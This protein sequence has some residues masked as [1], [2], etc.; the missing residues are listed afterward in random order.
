MKTIQ[1]IDEME[2]K[3]G[4]L[5]NDRCDRKKAEGSHPEIKSRE[6]KDPWIHKE[7]VLFLR[8]W[9]T[10]ITLVREG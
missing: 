4:V 5:F 8:H 9:V 6:I 7:N 2:M 10:K 3:I 1:T